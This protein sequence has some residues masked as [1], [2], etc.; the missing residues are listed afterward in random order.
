MMKKTESASVRS[1]VILNSIRGIMNLLFPLITF[2]YIANILGKE[3]LGQYTFSNNIIS[4]FV[5]L[6]G[7]GINTYSMREGAKRREDRPAFSAF[8]SDIFAINAV[9]TLISYLILFILIF[10]AAFLSDY[11]NLLIILS[12]QIVFNTLGVEWICTSVEDYRFITVRSIIVNTVSLILMFVLV[13]KSEDIRIYALLTV[14]VSGI[15]AVF[16]QLRVREYAD[17]RIAFRGESLV[18]VKPL[19][20]FFSM[21]VAISVYV[22]SDTTILGLLCDDGTVGLYSVSVKI[23]QVVKSIISYAMVVAIPRLSSFIGRKEYGKFKDL[24]C[25]IYQA[26]LTFIVPAVTGII[27]MR[28]DIVLVISNADYINATSSTVLLSVSLLFCALAWFWGQC[29]LVPF[30]K[31]NTVFKITVVSAMINI[32]L[33]LILIPVMKENAAALTTIISELFSFLWCWREGKKLAPI[34]IKRITY[35]KIIAGCAALSVL[36]I[37]LIHLIGNYILRIIIIVPA[38][39]VLY[40]ILEY[41]LCNESVKDM[42]DAF[43]KKIKTKFNI[44]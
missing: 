5:L 29:I 6:A 37:C 2:P 40:L 21:N 33:N 24:A 39:A 23:I 25:S 27:L 3:N 42:I 12:L 8:C 41:L 28:K 1:N 43:L 34:R 30:G 17:L 31:E 32:A 11:R 4:Y 15:S 20:V 9:S 18:H 7:L 36:V 22:N 26:L 44:F 16:N 10:N 35:L 38:S 14:A 13:K 19:I